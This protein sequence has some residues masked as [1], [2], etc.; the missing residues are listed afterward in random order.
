MHRMKLDIEKNN[1]KKL[2]SIIMKTNSIFQV[3]IVY[4]DEGTD[5]TEWNSDSADKLLEIT[6]KS[7]GLSGRSLRKLPLLAHA[8]YI[9]RDSVDLQTYL[10]ALDDAIVKHM[11]DTI[12]IEKQTKK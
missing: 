10:Y 2:R 4:N 6:N 3:G 12:T 7:K 11:A 8:W 5:G 1:K 9:H